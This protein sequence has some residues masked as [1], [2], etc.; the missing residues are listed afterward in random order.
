MTTRAPQSPTQQRLAGLQMAFSALVLALL[1]LVVCL[2]AQAGP[3]P[4]GP[5]A[6]EV[7]ARN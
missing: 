1:A 6:Q 5:M 4:T 3:A 7:S 2:L